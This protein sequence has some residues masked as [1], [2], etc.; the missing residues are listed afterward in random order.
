MPLVE[1]KRRELDR[2]DVPRRPNRSGP[3]PD[4]RSMDRPE[5]AP[6]A[7]SSAAALA[8]STG[9]LDVVQAVTGMGGIGKTS[10]APPPHDRLR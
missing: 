1:G 7:R 8:A 4:R 10:A 2:R 5:A 3:G 6:T 9:D